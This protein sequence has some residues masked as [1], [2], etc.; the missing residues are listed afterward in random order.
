MPSQVQLQDDRTRKHPDDDLVPSQ[1]QLQVDRTR[2]HPTEKA[3]TGRMEHNT[4]NLP[5]DFPS[6][7]PQIPKLLNNHPTMNLENTSKLPFSIYSP[8][9]DNQETSSSSRL[10]METSEPSTFFHISKETPDTVPKN[11]F[12]KETPATLQGTHFSK[13]THDTPP[14]TPFSK[15]TPDNLPEIQ[16][17]TETTVDDLFSSTVM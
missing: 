7:K 14:E 5:T 16:T 1:V 13:E 9:L 3:R 15:E 12:S 8:S 4:L 2:K 17:S 6:I 11:P 10:F